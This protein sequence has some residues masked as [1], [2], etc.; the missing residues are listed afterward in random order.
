MIWL[1]ALWAC[2]RGGGPAGPAPEEAFADAGEDLFARV[3]EPVTLDGSGSSGLSFTW[4]FGDGQVL[5]GK[6][7]PVASHVYAAP[8]HFTAVLQVAGA[9]GSSD[10]DTAVVTVTWPP[11]DTPPVH[12]STLAATPSEVVAVQPDHDALAAVDR[13]THAVRVVP[14][15]GTPRAISVGASRVAVACELDEVRWYDLDLVQTHA[16]TLPWGSR[17]GG[18]AVVDDRVAVVLRGTGEVLW[19]DASGEVERIA[20]G[21]DPRGLAWTAD[22]LLVSRFRSGD[23]HGTL[24]RV[25]PGGVEAWPLAPDPGPDS[26]TDARGLPNLL[27]PIAVRPDGRVAVVGG[28]KANIYRGLVRDGLP[29]THDTAVRA[30]ARQVALDPGEGPVG[31]E[32][33][34]PHFDDRDRVAALAFHPRGDWLY[35]AHLGAEIV[36]IVDSYTMARVGAF[37]DVGHGPSG[38]WVDEA[39]QALW[40]YAELSREL[41][42][43]DLADPFTAQTEL[44]RIDLRAGRPEPLGDE[45]LL[46]KIVFHR[47]ADPRMTRS[48]YVSCAS[49]HPDGEHDGRTWDFTDRGEGLR[50][51]I[52]LRGTGGVPPLHWSANFDE[53]QDFEN[54]IRGPQAGDGFL[55]D[56]DFEATRD[57]LGAPKAGLSPELDAL[58]AWIQGLAP[59]R[60]PYR[61]PDGQLTAPAAAGQ[62][63]FGSP[64][65]GCTQCHPAP[66]Y[67][68]SAWLG[69]GVPLL[70][71]VGTLT[72]DS[73]QRLGGPLD[74]LDT[75]TLRGLF[76]TAP[77]L[78][79][80][81]APTVRALLEANQADDLHGATSHLDA[82]ELDQLEAFLLSLE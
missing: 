21:P 19:L 59:L 4:Q 57:T 81:S 1:A 43:Y 80:G 42:V 75:P 25:G 53:L 52:G 74:G 79:D 82:N 28:L 64:A 63:L 37:L 29:L 36:D 27:D 49:C 70:H 14:T 69:P 39:G 67:T 24:W 7:S 71:D 30:V 46:G 38:L 34:E 5:A 9:R 41:V 32:L 6:T 15:C 51:T 50:N 45:G 2:G 13:A 55:S 60:S 40:V 76:A 56:A 18:I 78:H 73:G 26:D 61:A 65:A 44:D 66:D 11:T 77:Y 35:V 58:A 72:P 22:G 8:G 23:D 16:F 62:I 31:A 12:A 33:A 47:S 17:P 48:G 3:G 20:V 68:D 54:D 10:T